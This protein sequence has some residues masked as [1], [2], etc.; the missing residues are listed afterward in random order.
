MALPLIA[1]GIGLASAIPSIF[2]GISAK[3]SYNK[4]ANLLEGLKL[5]MPE[6]INVVG[7]MLR[8]RMS[9][10][11]PGYE[12]A[13]TD[14]MNTIPATM[15]EVLKAADSPS[16]VL[17]MLNSIR[18]DAATNINQINV[19]NA[20]QKIQSESNYANFLSGVK[21]PMKMQI[22][23]YGNQAKANAEQARMTG[24][25]QMIQGITQGVSQGI[26]GGFGAYT[27]L[28]GLQNQKDLLGRLGSYWGNTGSKQGGGL[29]VLDMINSIKS[30]S[31]FSIPP[32]LY[33][34]PATGS[35]VFTHQGRVDKD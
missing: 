23:E 24:K 6:E 28:M 16:T 19:Q 3:K 20:L 15:R 33:S 18:G 21:A 1:A 32:G 27:G 2:G 34:A 26:Q 5:D 11:M 22:Q 9:K 35:T 12:S 30:S 8:Q 14:A 13:K 29:N 25:A 17:S 4:Y 7:E 10:D 31:G